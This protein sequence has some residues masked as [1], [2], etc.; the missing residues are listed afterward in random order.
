MEECFTDLTLRIFGISLQCKLFKELGNDLAVG[1]T[2]KDEKQFVVRIPPYELS[3][4][5]V[6]LEC[7]FNALHLLL[8]EKV[9]FC[10][11]THRFK[12]SSWSM[13]SFGNLTLYQSLLQ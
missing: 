12:F 5:C 4:K 3:A 6:S 11:F 7:F 10:C 9:S 2:G 1:V 13:L 8:V